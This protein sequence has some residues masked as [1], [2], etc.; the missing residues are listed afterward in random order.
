MTTNFILSLSHIHID[1]PSFLVRNQVCQS[2]CFTAVTALF[3]IS[4]FWI[5]SSVYTVSSSAAMP[6]GTPTGARR[7]SPD[8]SFLPSR[9]PP[10]YSF[11]FRDLQQQFVIGKDFPADIR[12][13]AQGKDQ[14][15]FFPPAICWETVHPATGALVCSIR[16]FC[17]LPCSSCHLLSFLMALVYHGRLGKCVG[18]TTEHF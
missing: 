5:S 15:G 11:P 10:R 17:L 2:E 13:G 16:N 7:P 12:P 4:S 8:S 3:M 14:K 6:T 9:A 1:D 18:R